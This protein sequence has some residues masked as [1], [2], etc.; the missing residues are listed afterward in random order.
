MDVDLCRAIAAA[1]FDDPS[2]V[3]FRKLSAQ[4]RFTAVQ[5]GEIDILNRNTTWTINRDTAVGMEF[6]LTLFYDGQGIMA[7]EASG[8]QKLEDLQGK[9]ICVLAGTTTE[10]NL[11]DQMSK[12]GVKDYKP[13][14]S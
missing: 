1:L 11:A 12:V 6:G 5:T 3:K 10:Q 8:I 4:E 14:V 13:V 2:K 7:T 9:S